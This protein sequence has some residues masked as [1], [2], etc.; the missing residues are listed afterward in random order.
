MPERR[1]HDNVRHGITTP[2]AA[3][4]IAVPAD[5]DIHLI[6]DCD[7]LLLDQPGRALVRL[8]D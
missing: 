7:R 3:F 8:P 1:T 5:L 6:C 4:D 2:F